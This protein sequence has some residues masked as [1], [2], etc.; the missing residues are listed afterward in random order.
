VEVQVFFF[1]L[2]LD[3]SA[4]SDIAVGIG[5]LIGVTTPENFNRP[6]FARNVIDFWERWHISLSEFIR[7]NLFI[8]IQMS[9]VRRRRWSPLVCANVAVGISFISCGLWHGIGTNFLL[10]GI[11]HC[12]GL[13]TVNVYRHFLTKLLGAKRIKAYMAD[14]RIRAAATFATYQFVAASLLTLFL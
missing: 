10:W 11:V 3:F 9:M 13:M 8:P 7:R 5:R 6:Y 4:Y 12:V 14:N 1:W 2:Y